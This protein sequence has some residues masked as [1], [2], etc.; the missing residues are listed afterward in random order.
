MLLAQPRYV[1]APADLLRQAL[2][3]Q[4]TLTTHSKPTRLENFYIPARH[5]AT[6]PW[7]S[8]A[9]WFYA[10]MLRWKQTESCA[11]HLAAVRTTYRP[12]L[13]RAA[14]AAIN[15]DIPVEN[16]KTER[17]FDGQTFDPAQHSASSA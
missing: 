7:V 12:D 4:L 6:F 15:P 13:Y 2:E 17:F 14:L 10:Q 1:G 11:D 16:S 3:G 9:L 5:T 8:H